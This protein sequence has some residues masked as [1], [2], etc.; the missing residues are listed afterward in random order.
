MHWERRCVWDHEG[1]QVTDGG[2]L[3][4]RLEKE[5]SNED[6]ARWF[7][8]TSHW[9]ELRESTSVVDK[10]MSVGDGQ[11][12]MFREMRSTKMSPPEWKEIDL[13]APD[14]SKNKNKTRAHPELAHGAPHGL[15]GLVGFPEEDKRKTSRNFGGE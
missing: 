4:R 6:F 8:S 7:A 11:L 15:L 2:W 14:P 5:R 13:T 1:V 12:G 3:P 10:E 9:G